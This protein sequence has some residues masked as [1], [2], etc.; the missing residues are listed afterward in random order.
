M[1]C[2]G[3]VIMCQSAIPRSWVRI[4]PVA[5]VYQRQ[6]SMPSLHFSIDLQNFTWYSRNDADPVTSN[7]N[8]PIVGLLIQRQTT[9]RVAATRGMKT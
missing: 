8:L 5:A 6:L 3:L 4:P 9:A 7:E 2:G 1:V